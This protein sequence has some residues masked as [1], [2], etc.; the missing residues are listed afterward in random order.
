MAPLDPRAP[1]SEARVT[2]PQSPL[3]TRCGGSRRD[4]LGLRTEGHRSSS[5]SPSHPQRCRPSPAAGSSEEAEMASG[6]LTASAR[7]ELLT[8][9]DVAVVFTPEEWGHLRPA[10]K[11]LYR[12]VMLENY[13]NLVCLGLVISKPDVI[14]QLERGGKLWMPEGDV[15]RSTCP[16][17]S[18]R[19][20]REFFVS[21]SL[22]SL[23]SFS[24]IGPT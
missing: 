17:R 1:L 9:R 21:Q 11:E 12:D 10:Q 2:P 4:G 5:L 24:V 7:Q 23:F 13:R 3:W 20:L 16:G 6:L 15:L 8:F 14:D 22:F 18:L 19:T